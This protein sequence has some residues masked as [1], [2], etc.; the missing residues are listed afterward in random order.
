MQIHVQ[1]QHCQFK[2]LQISQYYNMELRPQN[3]QFMKI[4]I[5]DY[6]YHKKYNTLITCIIQEFSH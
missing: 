6:W 5:Q 4:L 3:K 1:T 2:I